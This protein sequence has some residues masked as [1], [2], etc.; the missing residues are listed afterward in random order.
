MNNEQIGQCLGKVVL[1][2]LGIFFFGQA[3]I[4]GANLWNA[5]NGYR[6]AMLDLNNRKA[7]VEKY[8]RV[9]ATLDGLLRDLLQAEARG[10]KSV[11][12]ILENAKIKI[13]PR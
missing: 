2:S 12:S 9:Q 5:C 6:Q 10:N 11:K 8:T 4:G 1:L 7:F 3:T 13:E